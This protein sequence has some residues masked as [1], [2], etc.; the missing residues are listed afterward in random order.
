MKYSIFCKKKDF[1]SS[2]VF[3]FR[4]GDLE[5]LIKVKVGQDYSSRVNGVCFSRQIVDG[6]I[7]PM[8][9]N[10]LFHSSCGTN[11]CWKL[12]SQEKAREIFLA[13]KLRKE[14]VK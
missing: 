10:R 7:Y 3:L 5:E 6:L 9:K 12:V 14:L 4:G 2:G 11:C 1:F 8:E 13:F